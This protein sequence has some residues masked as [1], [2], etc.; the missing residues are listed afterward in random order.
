MSCLYTDFGLCLW[1]VSFVLYMF[2]VP[3]IGSPYQYIT[4][5]DATSVFI[6]YNRLNNLA[7]LLTIARMKY[8]LQIVILLVSYI[9]SSKK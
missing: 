6:W 9:V 2:L 3:L 8:Q 4:S 1:H 7:K 5:N